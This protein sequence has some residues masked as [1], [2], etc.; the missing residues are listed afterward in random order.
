MDIGVF[1]KTETHFHGRL[2]EYLTVTGQFH[3]SPSFLKHE[4]NCLLHGWTASAKCMA[5]ERMD[6]LQLV[7]ELTSATDNNKCA[8]FADLKKDFDTTDHNIIIENWKGG[9]RGVKLLN[10]LYQN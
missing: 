7:E 6:Q 3:C 10:S 5:S 4:R 8:V 1:S 9:I 2:K